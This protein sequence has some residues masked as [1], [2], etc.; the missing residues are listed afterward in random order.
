VIERGWKKIKK[1]VGCCE[2]W[3]GGDDVD[4]WHALL[5]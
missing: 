4:A 5:E 2:L 1:M 3:E